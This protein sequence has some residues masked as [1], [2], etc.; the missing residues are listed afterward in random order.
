[1]RKLYKNSRRC[2]F[3]LELVKLADANSIVNTKT[4]IKAS[5]RAGYDQS[6]QPAQLIHNLKASGYV[7]LRD[8]GSYEIK[9]AT[10]K[11]LMRLQLI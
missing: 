9:W 6:T 1:M 5:E 3:V 2:L 4:A 8:R 11:Q 7:R 10:V